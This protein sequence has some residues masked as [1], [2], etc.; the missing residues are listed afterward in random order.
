MFVYRDNSVSNLIEQQTKRIIL[1][2]HGITM[3]VILCTT[4]IYR[5][6]VN[7]DGKTSK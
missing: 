3:Y 4:I 7:S 5:G 6:K 2:P 1:G